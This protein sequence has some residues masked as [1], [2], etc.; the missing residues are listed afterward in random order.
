ML[1]RM[2]LDKKIEKWSPAEQFLAREIYELKQKCPACR[3]N[4]SGLI[5]G[6]GAG[7]SGGAITLIGQAILNKLLGGG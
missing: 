2:E 5:I 3:V 4:K 7:I 1:N 6:S